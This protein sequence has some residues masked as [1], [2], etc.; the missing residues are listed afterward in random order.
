MKIIVAFALSFVFLTNTASAYTVYCTNCSD[1]FTQ[2]IER[3]TNLEQLQSMLKAYDEYVMQTMQQVEMVRQNV[4]QYT[5]MIQNTVQLPQNLINEVTS[6][7]Q[8]LAQVTNTLSTLRGDVSALGQIHQSLYMG[9]DGLRG[10]VSTAPKQ[11]SQH[12]QQYRQEWDKWS[13]RVDD[14]SKATFQLSG[15]QLQEMQ[16]DSSKFQSYIN[17]LLSTPDG[18]QKAIMAGNQLAALQI[19]EMRQLRELMA[20]Q[21]QSQL[22]SQEKNE[23]EAQMSEEMGRKVMDASKLKNMSP[24]DD[25]F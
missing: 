9:Q 3:V 11:M 14:A 8:K 25:P 16:Q 2:A 21:A 7:F 15:A 24:K 1:K 13:R 10:I 12:N 22:A 20:T 6:N 18:Q 5:N 4:E 23:K 19:Q 17:D